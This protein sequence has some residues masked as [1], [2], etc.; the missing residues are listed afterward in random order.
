MESPRYLRI[1]LPPFVLYG[2]VILAHALND[3][4]V[5]T[6]AG[7]ESKNI[8]TVMAAIIAASIVPAGFVLGGITR[9][10]FCILEKIHW[11]RCR[12]VGYGR[13]DLLI[14]DEHS[15]AVLTDMGVPPTEWTAEA[16]LNAVRNFLYGA[17][18]RW[19]S[20]YMNRCWDASMAYSGSMIGVL[21]AASYFCIWV[22][23]KC[24]WWWLIAGVMFL[25]FWGACYVARKE[26]DTV[27]TFQIKHRN[28]I[29][30]AVA[31][32][33]PQK[34]ARPVSDE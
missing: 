15:R 31:Q 18:D 4:L 13:Y 23:P 25:V 28:S 26:I 22:T 19:L 8:L 33:N 12:L 3:T 16:R 11:G 14:Q 10:V 20:D 5:K 24:W 30:K 34:A 29:P 21:L 9:L 27:I 6:L 7:W 17:T 2:A 32:W 1:A